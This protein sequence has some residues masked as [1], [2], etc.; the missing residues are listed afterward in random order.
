MQFSKYLIP[1]TFN[2]VLGDNKSRNL[3]Y[4]HNFKKQI[5]KIFLMKIN[6]LHFNQNLLAI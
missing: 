2:A 3:F 6:K 1:K 4:F 5:L